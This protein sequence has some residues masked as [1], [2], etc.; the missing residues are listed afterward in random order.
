M[1]WVPLPLVFPSQERLGCILH[2]YSWFLRMGREVLDLE[3]FFPIFWDNFFRKSFQN[4]SKI[5]RIYTRK[6]KK[7]PKFFALE[8]T[9][10]FVPKK[11]TNWS[12]LVLACVVWDLTNYWYIGPI[13]L[14]WKPIH[15][16]CYTFKLKVVGIRV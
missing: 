16:K 8:K 14:W 11:I 6:N 9:R 1:W 7:I 3:S 12:M 5:R 2:K 15:F 10:S 13:G 4:V